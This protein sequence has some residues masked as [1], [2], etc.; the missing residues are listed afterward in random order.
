MLDIAKPFK[1]RYNPKIVKDYS[2]L[3]H[4][5][6]TRHK[7]LPKARGKKLKICDMIIEGK[8]YTLKNP[9]KISD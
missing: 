2:P 5:K 3:L 1:P 9:E 6:E 7:G 4:S 8:S